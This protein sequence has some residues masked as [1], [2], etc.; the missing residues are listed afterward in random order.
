VDEDVS[1][2][3]GNVVVDEVVDDFPA[4]TS[5]RYEAGCAKSPQMLGDEGLR[6]R[7]GIHEFVDATR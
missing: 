2:D 6:D 1:R 7:Q 3:V 4:A 5:S